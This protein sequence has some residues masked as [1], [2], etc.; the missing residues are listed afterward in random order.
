MIIF[1]FRIG[2]IQYLD[3]HELL[4]WH[5]LY[6]DR[7]WR[8]LAVSRLSLGRALLRVNEMVQVVWV[9]VLR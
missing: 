3:R 4:L 7:R 2:Y 8:E 5:V 9:W 1:P 6:F